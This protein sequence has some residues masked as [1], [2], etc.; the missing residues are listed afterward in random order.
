MIKILATIAAM[1]LA[2]VVGVIGFSSVTVSANPATRIQVAGHFVEFEGTQ[3]IH[4]DGVIHVPVRGVFTLMGFEPTW[5][6]VTDTATLYDGYTRIII[7]IGQSTFTVNGR[8]VTPEVPQK[9]VGGRVL[10]PLRAVTEA[11]GGTANWDNVN[12]VAVITPPE[13]LMDR[14]L[15]NLGIT[16]PANNSPSIIT[17]SI[18]AGHVGQSFT[19]SLMSSGAGNV[20]TIQSGNLPPGLSLDATTGV[21]L[22]TPTTPGTFNFT[23]RVQ[24]LFGNDTRGLTITIEGPQQHTV[25]FNA[26]GGTGT[27]APQMFE[28]GVAQDL[29][30][31]NFIKTGYTLA[32]WRTSPTGTVVQY[33]NGQRITVTSN[34]TLYAVWVRGYS[35]TFNANGGVGTMSPQLFQRGISQNLHTNAFTRSGYNFAGW[36]TAPTGTTV[37]YINGQSVTI[38]GNRTLYAVWVR[39][40]TV[41]FNANGGTGTMDPQVFQ[42]GVAQS[43]RANTFTRTGFTFVGWR[44]TPT[45]I[46]IHHT[47]GQNVTVSSN[48]T[49]YAVWTQGGAPVIETTTLPIAQ[50]GHSYSHT[51]TVS[52]GTTPITWSIEGGNLPPGLTLSSTG[53]ISG[54]PASAATFY[55]TV[56]AQNAAGF[57]DR[58]FTI[59]VHDTVTVTGISVTTMPSRT[60]FLVGESFD[61]SGMV[62]TATL[63]NGTTRVATGFTTHSTPFDAPGLY[64]ITINYGGHSTSFSVSVT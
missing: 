20:W 33:N 11:I 43:L 6:P 8:V 13:D 64:T 35:I 23:V 41:T 45:G 52:S 54:T 27:M 17:T 4:Q 14:V 51:L 48:I 39:G 56:R 26:N 3:P 61:S 29:R 2:I 34:R 60:N 5:D 25:T 50:R 1:A 42:P 10:I 7:P 31:N 24:N 49:L 63:S 18:P 46:D 15:E 21:I 32:G 40:F 28:H 19:Q 36:R 9:N 30:M 44:T 58:Q 57:S 16:P 22:G 37:Q 59:V 47:N 55:F 12:R 53:V 38:S 62:V